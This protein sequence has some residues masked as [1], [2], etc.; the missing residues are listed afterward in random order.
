MRLARESESAHANSDPIP[1][2]VST[3]WPR[4][5]ADPPQG[6]VDRTRCRRS[7]VGFASIPT[8]L[9]SESKRIATRCTSTARDRSPSEAVPRDDEGGS[10]GDMASSDHDAENRPDLPRKEV[11]TGEANGTGPHVA[12]AWLRLLAEKIK[13]AFGLDPTPT[14][15]SL[16]PPNEEAPPRDGALDPKP[17]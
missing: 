1:A 13:R 3:D 6:D 8:S 7:F 9:A 14:P 2:I 12:P 4:H 16:K 10:R 11:P 15:P 5:G 17:G